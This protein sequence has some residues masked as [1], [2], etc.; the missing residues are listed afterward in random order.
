[1]A[2]FT[3]SL[4]STSRCLSVGRQSLPRASPRFSTSAIA[5]ADEGE[6]SSP[7]SSSS[8]SSGPSLFFP[9][10]SSSSASAAANAG[11]TPSAP[12]NS[13]PGATPAHNSTY[14]YYSPSRDLRPHRLHVSSS[15]NNTLITLAGQD[16]SKLVTHTGGSVGF[17]GSQKGGYEAAYRAAL[18][19]FESIAQRRRDRVGSPIVR[20]EL[21]FKGFGEGRE[22]VYRALLSPEGTN[23]RNAVV[24]ISD[25][26]KLK[27]GG[28][29]AKKQKSECREWA[30]MTLGSK[31]TTTAL[32]PSSQ[33]PNK[34]ASN[35]PHAVEQ[36]PPQNGIARAYMHSG[37]LPD[38][39][40]SL[41]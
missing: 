12:Q 20:M 19:M 10:A 16:G 22:A 28:T 35:S 7:P 30:M 4:A 3:R 34:Q 25:A 5:R 23:V 17:K 24:F 31:L 21:V 32:S 6:S 41:S 36:N 29:R 14:S 26:T 11:A 38:L 33:S 8:S 2:T 9:S 40:L 18:A 13:L 27:I 39:R 15:P 1:M 37:C